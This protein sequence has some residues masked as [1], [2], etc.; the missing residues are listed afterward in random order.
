MTETISNKTFEIN[1]SGN[2]S[3]ITR[4][5]VLV[6]NSR[7]ELRYYRDG[8]SIPKSDYLKLKRKFDK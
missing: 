6:D 3:V 8:E 5:H 7:T 1:I 2:K 4:K